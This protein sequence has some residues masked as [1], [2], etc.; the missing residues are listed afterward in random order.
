MEAVYPA[1]I[2]NATAALNLVL[3]LRAGLR[4]PL[5]HLGDDCSLLDHIALMQDLHD[6][7]GCRVG[8]VEE[9]ALPRL[10]GTQ[11][12]DEAFEI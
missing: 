1:T 3:N 12:L 8:I 9:R 5:V 2:A 6:L 4:L 10:I 7:L 11:V